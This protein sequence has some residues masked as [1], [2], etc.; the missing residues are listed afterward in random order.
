M[1]YSQIFTVKDGY[2]LC[3]T[4]GEVLDSESFIRWGLALVAKAQE[5]RASKVLVDNRTFKLR[6][7]PL[8]VITFADHMEKI[9]GNR[10]GLR[11]AVISCVQN[12]DVSRLVETAL[13]NRSASYKS[14]LNQKEAQEWL[15]GQPR[16]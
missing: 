5:T 6:L 4:D 3:I 9:G 12:L 13:V 2:L 1:T 10:L 14:F 7:T 16:N 11:L 8:D 15:L